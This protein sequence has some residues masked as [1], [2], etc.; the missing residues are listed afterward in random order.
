[1]LTSRPRAKLQTRPAAGQ[2]VDL[3][4][5][6]IRILKA[7]QQDARLSFRELSRQTRASVPTVSAHVHRLERLGVLGGYRADVDPLQLGATSVFLVVE[8]AAGQTGK[9]ASAI[10][11]L[12]EVR[13]TV[14]TREGRIVAE[15]ILLRENEAARF[16]RRVRKLRG[17]VAY[18][19]HLASRRVKDEPRAH[20]AHG[21]QVLVACFEC[22]KTIEGA[23]V[24][25]RLDRREH[26]F[27]CRTCEA[28]FVDR[29]R[30][31]KAAA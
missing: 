24:I 31:L 27:C 9:V 8:A 1:M 28:Q 26:Y 11:R 30:R 29:Y 2:I 17:V 10:A 4:P 21:V 25:R 12:P 16:L 18:E 7:L 22:G 20:V 19:H 15:A 13:R 3:D 5:L 14:E 6:D 23:P